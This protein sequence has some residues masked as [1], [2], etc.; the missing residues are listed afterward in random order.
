[1]YNFNI[2]KIKIGE[3]AKHKQTTYLISSNILSLF[4]LYELIVS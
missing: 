3:L 4:N 2:F 1:M